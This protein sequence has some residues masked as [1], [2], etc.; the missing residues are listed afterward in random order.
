MKHPSGYR[1]CEALALR[2]VSPP[3]SNNLWHCYCLRCLMDDLSCLVGVVCKLWVTGR[4]MRIHVRL[5]SGG[6]KKQEWRGWRTLLLHLLF[7]G[8]DHSLPR[9]WEKEGAP[10]LPSCASF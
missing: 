4:G 7:A 10:L 8:A 2:R 9:L 1:S 5:K 3:T 6:F